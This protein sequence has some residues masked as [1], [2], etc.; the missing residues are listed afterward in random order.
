MRKFKHKELFKVTRNQIESI[1]R[2]YWSR[3]N[4]DTLESMLYY[5]RNTNQFR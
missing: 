5:K 3:Y 2:E 4:N 1:E